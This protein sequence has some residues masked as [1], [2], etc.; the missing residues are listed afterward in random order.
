MKKIGFRR[1]H[2]VIVVMLA[3]GV[4]RTL[5]YFTATDEKI[6]TIK[7]AHNQIIPVEEFERPIIGE[8]TVKKPQAK[9]VGNIDCYVRA[10]IL[11]SDSRAERSI[12]YCYKN[13]LG[14]NGTDWS[15]NADGWLYYRLALGAGEVTTPV[16]DHI[17]LAENV[18]SEIS[19]LNID[20]IFESVQSEGFSNAIEAFE[21]I[22]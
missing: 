2:I 10:R 15:E 1:K 21:A 17:R 8:K 5:A 4:S 11:L 6:N 19:E 3:I 18:P 14:F 22:N 9:N 16:F 13:T 7:I 20:V 12:E